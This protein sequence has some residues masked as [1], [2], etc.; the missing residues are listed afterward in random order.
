MVLLQTC[1]RLELVRLL[2]S[3]DWCFNLF[4][5]SILTC[6]LFDDCKIYI[7]NVIEMK[8]VEVVSTN[9]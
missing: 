4:E 6:I 7:N 8:R 1:K 9:K 3:E 2:I 5:T